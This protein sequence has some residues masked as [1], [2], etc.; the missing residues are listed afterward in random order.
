[1]NVIYTDVRLLLDRPI[2]ITGAYL[3]LWLQQA[4]N[5]IIFVVL[6]TMLFERLN[7]SK[8]GLK[9]IFIR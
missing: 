5:Q 6:T 4:G 8:Y 1:M 2:N 3:P 9:L 7:T